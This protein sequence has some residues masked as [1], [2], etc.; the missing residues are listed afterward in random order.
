MGEWI[1]LEDDKTLVKGKS[2]RS[3]LQCNYSVLKASPG[4][5]MIVKRTI[6][7]ELQKYLSDSK[8]SIRV[9]NEDLS[10]SDASFDDSPKKNR[11]EKLETRPLT[12]SPSRSSQ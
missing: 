6:Q 9:M 11:D 5:K 7:R 3:R 2:K 4:I 8:F 1:D 10:I 12:E